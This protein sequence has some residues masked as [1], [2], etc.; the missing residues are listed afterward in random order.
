MAST[1]YT[2]V[3]RSSRRSSLLVEIPTLHVYYDCWNCSC[4]C[5]YCGAY[6]WYQERALYLS[7][8]NH[9]RYTKCCNLG[10]VVLPYPLRPPEMLMQFYEDDHFMHNI[11]AY[12]SMF[13]MTSFGANEDHSIN[14]GH[15]PYVF[16]VSG[17]IYHWIGSFCPQD[18]HQPRFLQL[19]MCDTENEVANRLHSFHGEGEVLLSADVVDSFSQMLNTHNEYIRTFKTAKEIAQSMNLDSY[20]VRLFGNVPDRGYGPPAPGSLGCIVCGDDVTGAVYDIVVYS[21]SGSVRRVSKLHPTYMPLQYPLLFP[22]GEEGWSPTLHLRIDSNR[23]LTNNVYYSYKI[24]DRQNYSLILHAPLRLEYIS[25]VYDALDKGDTDSRVIGFML[26]HNISS[27][28]LA[29][30]NGLS[31]E[32]TWMLLVGVI[33][34]TDQISL[35]TSLRSKFM[36]SLTSLKKTK[37]LEMSVHVALPFK[38]QEGADIDKYITVELPNPILE[39]ELYRTVTTC[40]L[41]GPCGLLNTGAP[42]MVDD[43]CVKR[44]PKPFNSL[45]TFDENGYMHYRRRV[46]PYHVLQSGVRTDNG[47]VVSYNKRLC[48][49]FDAHINVEY[50]GWNMVIKYLFKYISKGVDRVRFT[51]QTSEANTTTS[52][53]TIPVAVNE[54]KSFLD[55]AKQ[56]NPIQFIQLVVRFDPLIAMNGFGLRDCIPTGFS[57]KTNNNGYKFTF[58]FPTGKRRSYPPPAAPPQVGR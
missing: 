35:H 32:D 2:I 34:K 31:I 27:L 49:R 54:I 7:Q 16:K 10:N 41:H 11:I 26:S 9:P 33:F 4:V 43:R 51:L 6:F 45:T 5:E 52:S 42:C 55:A 58:I 13:S 48:S 22:Y 20:S 15:A 39:P 23:S 18:V 3:P 56:W 38:I 12:K 50:C 14:K 17:Q 36:L 19:Y 24:H 29:I 44:F 28:S 53:S 40:M 46:G 57:T 25:G 21:K 37:F 30:S 1:S 47:Y 8:A